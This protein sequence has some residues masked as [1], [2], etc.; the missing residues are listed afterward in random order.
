MPSAS[1]HSLQVAEVF[2]A[3]ETPLEGLAPAEA[4]SRL[5]LY[6]PNLLREPP[7]APLWRKFIRH[8][9]HLMAALL[10]AAGGLAI[11]S[12]R[13]VLGLV[14]WSVVLIN[15]AFSFWQE[16]RAERALAAL[17]HMLPAYARVMRGGQE[18]R[19]P[20]SEIVPGDLLMLAEGDHVPGDARVVEEYGLRVN[21]ATLTGEAMP[22]RK[23]AEASLREGLSD[24][25]R[26]N[27]IFAGTSVV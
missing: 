16:H 17:R 3:L 8:I 18:L 10:W 20:A 25:E 7:A 14:I 27:L 6:G 11:I 19:I 13:P 12:G 22:T 9:A 26:P 15:A 24:L 23:T 1:L 21:Q 4:L 5:T 2:R